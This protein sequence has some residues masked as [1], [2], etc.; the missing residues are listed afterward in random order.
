HCLVA[1]SAQTLPLVGEMPNLPGLVLFTG[2][3]H[4]LVY[5]PPL[6][7]KL[8]HHL[9][10]GREPVIDHLAPLLNPLQTEK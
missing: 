1:F 4:P 6:A 2:F 9:T 7:Q 10:G 8:A 3:T 5:V